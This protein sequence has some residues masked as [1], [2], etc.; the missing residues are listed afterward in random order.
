MKQNHTMQRRK[1]EDRN[2]KAK[3]NATRG[4]KEY[5]SSKNKRTNWRGSQHE[6]PITKKQSSISLLRVI[7][8]SDLVLI[9]CVCVSVYVRNNNKNHN[10]TFFGHSTHSVTACKLYVIYY[11]AQQN[12]LVCTMLPASAVTWSVPRSL[13]APVPMVGQTY[14]K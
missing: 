13:T 5:N 10:I 3:M 9:M 8:V 6:R 2:K 4:V 12:M 1:E 14:T 11:V 7:V